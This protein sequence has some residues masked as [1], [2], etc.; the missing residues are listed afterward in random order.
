[1]RLVGRFKPYNG[2]RLRLVVGAF[3]FLFCA[4][5]LRLVY[6]Q[7]F[8][9][10]HLRTLAERQYNRQ[11]TLHP[12]RGR[13]LDRHGRVL[14]TSVPVPSVYA[15]PQDIEDTEAAAKKVAAVLGQPAATI[16]RLLD[17]EATFVWIARQLPPEVG[18]RIQKLNIRGVQVLQ[19]TRR[20]YPKRHLAG[21][22]LG[23][24]GVDGAGLGG[25]EHLYNRE[26]TG[27]PHR[28]RLQRDATGRTVQVTAGDPSEQPR[29][30]DLY[31]TLDERLQYIA[32]KELAT[33]M[34]E[35]QAKSGIVVVMHP[36]T[37]DILALANYPAFNPNDFQDPK[38]RPW[39]RNRGVTD[40]YEPGSTFKVVA[41]SAALEENVAR[42]HEM[43]HC[44]NGFSIRNGKRRLRDHHP[45][46]LLSFVQVIEKSS[47][48]GTAKIA[49]R[50]SD[51]TFYNYIRRF[52]FGEKTLVNLPGEEE[53]FVRVPKKWSKPTHDSL[54]IGQEITVTPLQ[55]AN[56]YA[57][58]ANG[59]WLMRPRMVEH[60][61]QGEEAQFFAPAARHRILSPQTLE[62]INEILVG[63]VER[64]TGK[65]AMVEGYT[66]AGKTGTAQKVE[67]GTYSHSKVM[68]S[69]VGYVPAEAP[70]LAIVVMIDEPQRA[71]WGGEAAAPV[72]KKVAQQA[73]YYLQV[74]SRQT[75]TLSLEA[76]LNPAAPLQPTT[77]DLPRITLS[78][79]PKAGEREPTRVALSTG[80]KPE[81]D[82]RP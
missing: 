57:A 1:M 70:Q 67:H 63:V 7:V 81:K 41:A 23:F 34:Q 11:I 35:T 65:Q 68:A 17:A 25:L 73:L 31:L 4:I 2:R 48:I 13:I 8:Q 75:Q 42:V 79:G 74:P 76:A 30:A 77:P 54:A 62:R 61:V 51:Q 29:G 45:Y 12:E 71:K 18:E 21:Q 49:E 37:G 69:F 22:V 52:G 10:A 64:G 27:T 38:Q 5:F 33:R 53:G 16:E 50:L 56:A 19:E 9:H 47:N 58:V 14:A 80:S 43:F 78:T 3:A 24:V 32:E 28:V 6:V 46:G 40:P 60:I 59:G 26:L 55:M 15:I 82:R 39:Q 36:P 66:A 44:E 72:F 20:F